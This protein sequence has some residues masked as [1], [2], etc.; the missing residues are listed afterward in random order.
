M[1]PPAADEADDEVDE[2]DDEEDEQLEDEDASEDDLFE[3]GDRLETV[4][5]S[6]TR[7]SSTTRTLKTRSLYIGDLRAAGHSR[8]NEGDPPVRPVAPADGGDV[9]GTMFS[10]L[11]AMS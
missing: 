3:Y 8:G 9:R 10:C 5:A 6:T 2:S 11:G 4:I 1:N 7:I